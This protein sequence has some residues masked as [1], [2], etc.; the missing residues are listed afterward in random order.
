VKTSTILEKDKNE[1]IVVKP[2]RLTRVDK[3]ELHV[4]AT[5]Q[6]LHTDEKNTTL[7]KIKEEKNRKVKRKNEGKVVFFCLTSNL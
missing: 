7:G 2:D 4:R 3:K 6:R 1:S 5:Q